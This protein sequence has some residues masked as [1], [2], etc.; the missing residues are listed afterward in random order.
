MPLHL[1]ELTHEYWLDGIKYDSVT[2]ILQALGLSRDYSGISSFYAERG[3]AVHKAVEFVDKGTL[4]EGTVSDLVRPYL[5][6]YRKF[7]VE[8]GYR[9]HAWE[10]AL[11]H[12][13]LRYAGTID[14][15]GFLKDRLGILDIKTSSSLD[16]S[17]EDQLSAYGLLWTEHHSDLPVRWRYALQLTDDGKYNLC[18]KYSEAPMEDWLSIMTVFRKK[19][20]R[21]A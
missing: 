9:A 12:P 2:K 1:D 6:A 15:V 11:H 14:K 21:Q 10:V 8:S 3:R 19:Q 20:K 16:P 13:V 5:S 4:D 17:V 18:T 7:L